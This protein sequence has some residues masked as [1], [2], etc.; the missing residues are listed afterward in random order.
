MNKKLRNILKFEQ[1]AV[2]KKRRAEIEIALIFP[3]T[4]HLGMSSLSI[5]LFY[6]RINKRQDACCERVFDFK[7]LKS[8]LSLENQRPLEAFD[9]LAVS[10]S[11]ESDYLNFVQMLKKSRVEQLSKNRNLPLIIVGGI[12]TQINR[13]PLSDFVDAFVLG[14]GEETL[15]RILDIYLQFK[16]NNFKIKK[17]EFLHKLA[18][19]PGVYVPQ[20]NNVCRPVE[21][22]D[23]DKFPAHSCIVT[24][25]TEFENSFLVELSRGCRYQCK[26]CVLSGV[27][28]GMRYRSLACVMESIEQGLM[29]TKRVGLLAAAVSDYPHILDLTVQLIKRKIAVSTS[30]LRIDSTTAELIKNLVRLGQ[31]TITFAPETGSE[32]LRMK[33]GKQITNAAIIKKIETAKYL[34]VKSLKLYFMIGLPQETMKDIDEI[35][36]LVKIINLILKIKVSITVFVPKPHTGF[37]NERFIAKDEFINK[38]KHIKKNLISQRN[39]TIVIDNYQC[40]KVQHLVD[41]AGKDYF[42]N[43][44]NMSRL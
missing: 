38:I 15:D 37:E 27:L 34:G 21:I 3:N 17:A 2:F 23:L 20:I 11:F 36:S 35:I 31:K 39:I 8:P 18:E 4:Y 19:I 42:Y 26:F 13:E 10:I 12:M 43:I 40:A 25:N 5:H 33:L 6:S 29:L 9:I 7:E 24:P 28:P 14:D 1:G 22:K 44:L 41:Y 30:S 32:S 16:K